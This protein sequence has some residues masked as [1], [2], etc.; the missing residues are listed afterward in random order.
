[1]GKEA[2]NKDQFMIFGSCLMLGWDIRKIT[3][4]KIKKTK[5]V[6]RK[7]RS[8]TKKQNNLRIQFYYFL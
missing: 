1:M 5:K 8:V 3:K 7:K 6:K 4:N 2:V